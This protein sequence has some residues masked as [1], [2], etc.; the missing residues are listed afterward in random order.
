MSRVQLRISLKSGVKTLSELELKN[1]SGRRFRSAERYDFPF[2]DE[3]S[4]FLTAV[5]GKAPATARR[6]RGLVERLLADSGVQDPRALTREVIE[7]HLRRLFT[8]GRGASVR[9]GVVVAVRSLCE[10][11]AGRGLVE[12]NPAAGLQGPSSF[13][14]AVRPLTVEEVKRLIW[15]D[16]QGYLPKGLRELRDRALLAVM[17]IGGLRA[18]EPGPIRLDDV[19]W[20]EA[21]ET[22]RLLIAHGK[23]A[24]GE[25][26]VELDREASRVLGAYLGV[27]PASPWLFVSERKGPLS[28]AAVYQIFGRRRKEAGIEVRGRRMSPHILRHSIATHLLAR[29]VDIRAVQVHLRHA[30]IETTALYTFADA[31]RVKR[32][33]QK[34]SPLGPQGKR[35]PELQRALSE[36]LGDLTL[37]PLKG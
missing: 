14:R 10:W 9:Q 15:G 19:Q 13:R 7:G 4:E 29:G 1:F 25:Q 5:R 11:L 20:D 2:L 34:R 27:R 26:W 23:G 16:R 6:Y 24:R 35:R 12:V 33:L 37:T 36:L 28:R 8:S 17:Y 18:S 31:G 3:W 30:S 32:M 22:F 21:A